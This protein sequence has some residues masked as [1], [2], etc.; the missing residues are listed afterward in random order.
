MI[1]RKGITKI[2]AMILSVAIVL[3]S[4]ISETVEA[5]GPVTAINPDDNRSIP[6]IS[7]VPEVY[8]VPVTSPAP[9]IGNTLNRQLIGPYISSVS[10]PDETPDQLAQSQT[11]K[12]FALDIFVIHNMARQG[13]GRTALKWD[14]QLEADANI[15]AKELMTLFSHTRPDGTYC[16]SLDEHI[17]GENIDEGNQPAKTCAVELLHSPGHR[18]NILRTDYTSVGIAVWEDGNGQVYIAE[19]FAW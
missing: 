3:A 7:S 16:Y 18:K 10:T 8:G 19:D 5:S 9:F 17:C 13:C 2:T 11:L 15:R 12:A 14:A 1:N 4:G 6:D